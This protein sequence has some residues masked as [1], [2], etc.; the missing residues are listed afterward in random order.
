M[1]RDS[2]LLLSPSMASFLNVELRL[3]W[4]GRQAAI[5]KR[6]KRF[7]NTYS[8]AIPAIAFSAFQTQ[9]SLFLVS[10]FGG[11]ANIAEVAALGRLGQIFAMLMTFNVM[12][13]EPYM[14]RCDTS[15]LL[16]TYLGL[17]VA[18]S[19]I[20]A[21]VVIFAFHFP[22]PF[23]WLLGGKYMSLRS[24]VGWVVMSACIMHLAGLIWIMNRSRK[25]V[26]WSGTAVEIGLLLT[27]QVAFLYVV[28]V[29]T[30][31]QAVMFSLISS[32]CYI[33]VHIYVGLLGFFKSDESAEST[34]LTT[35]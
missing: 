13:I 1:H 3:S 4:N 5:T 28:G 7:S 15:R 34:P 26:F 14:A 23:L 2:T 10:I 29:R 8:H 32:L 24:E 25:W 18:S 33:V 6:T 22:A 31:H 19:F 27:V 12:V 21:P 35:N 30:T 17:I 9:I 16:L 11:T 20:C